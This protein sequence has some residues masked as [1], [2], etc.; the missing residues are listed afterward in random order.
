MPM[1]IQCYVAGI[2]M[3]SHGTCRNINA[4]QF[5]ILS[6]IVD[7]LGIEK[8]IKMLHEQYMYVHVNVA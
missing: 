3:H 1:L 5:Y 7:N 4:P 6:R 2:S 8:S